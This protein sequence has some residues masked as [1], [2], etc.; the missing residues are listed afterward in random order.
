[1]LCSSKESDG[2]SE[3]MNATLLQLEAVA[4]L[5]SCRVTPCDLVSASSTAGRGRS[6]ATIRVSSRSTIQPCC[7]RE[8]LECPGRGSSGHRDFSGHGLWGHHISSQAH[9]PPL[10]GSPLPF[11]RALLHSLNKRTWQ[12]G[13]CESDWQIA[14]NRSRISSRHQHGVS[15]GQLPLAFAAL[16]IQEGPKTEAIPAVAP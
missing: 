8:S 10:P 13:Q 11:P 5:I 12:D 15:V 3:A 2:M 14:Q 9:P 6:G 1:M 7:P 4:R 16:R